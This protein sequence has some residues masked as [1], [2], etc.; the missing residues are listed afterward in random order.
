MAQSREQRRLAAIVAIDMVGY[1]RLV[2]LDE[3][4]TVASFKA[5]R[6]DLIDP[7]IADYGGRIVKT[8][9][10]GLLLEFVSAVD[11]VRCAIAIQE[12]MAARNADLP[13]DRRMVLRIGVNI[14]D[15]IIDGDDIFGDGVNIAARLE[16]LAEPGGIALSGMVAESVRG[17]LQVTLTD[18]GPQKLKNIAE[19]VSVFRI[20]SE[21]P[22]V[23]DRFRPPSL[24][25][26]PSIAVL[27]F[28]DL[29][30]EPGQEYFSDGIAEDIITELSRIRSL[31]VI[32]RNSTFMYKG[33]VVD[34]RKA[35]REL[36]VHYVLEG[37]V[38]RSGNRAR[39]TAQLIDAS[40]GVHV[41]AERYDRSLE[42]V[43]AVQDEVTRNIIAVLPGR[44]ESVELD[45]A[46]RKTSKSLEA[47]DHLLRGK[48]YHHLETPEANLKAEEHFT[49]S[50]Q[51]DPTFAAAI[52]WKACTLG[53]AWNR[54]FRPREPEQYAEIN[55]LVRS[56]LEIDENDAECHRIMCRLS[57]NRRQFTK[58]DHHLDRALALTPNDPRLIVQRGIN[59]TYL[60]DPD[61][62]IAWIERAIRADP[63][64][65]GRYELDL[66]RALYVAGRH[67]EA[68]EVLES[69]ARTHYE[70]PVLLAACHS[71]AGNIDAARQAALAA[72]ALRPELTV[73][74]FMSSQPWK[75]ATDAERLGNALL[76][77]GLPP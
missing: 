54:E 3:A 43:F 18:M 65:A 2:G 9:G 35:A 66:A 21:Q 63:F 70:S 57:L 36:G 69:L 53:Q 75:R 23:G 8:T 10:D 59:L 45:L 72:L 20:A 48:Y 25:N 52:A 55:R 64:S 44:V 11:A 46:A 14:G 12:G 61:A 16:Q 41:W 29:S 5:H 74:S 17:K 62:A 4:G 56:A 24:Q 73:A 7:E 15:V 71:A 77:A 58:S 26:R 76:R 51:K 34:V 33:K 38:R 27:P 60:G 39:I 47:Y 37:S 22:V 31:F 50:I 13:N 49:Q 6:R 19:S 67:V 1:S 32:A 30:G 68:V 28:V 40:N 42:D